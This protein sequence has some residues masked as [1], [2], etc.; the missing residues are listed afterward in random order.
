MVQE[1]GAPKKGVN[2]LLVGCVTIGLFGA[3]CVI[4]VAGSMM[5]ATSESGQAVMA[6]AVAEV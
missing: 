2:W 6:T 4:C 5:F 3:V 1:V